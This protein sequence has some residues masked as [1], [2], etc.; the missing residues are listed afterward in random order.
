MKWSYE[1]TLFSSHFI[2]VKVHFTLSG[3]ISDFICIL[4]QC[5]RQ[6][7]AIKR[8]Y[9]VLQGQQQQQQKKIVNIEIICTVEGEIAFSF[10]GGCLAKEAPHFQWNFQCVVW[11]YKNIST[12]FF[13][14]HFPSI[15]YT[16]KLSSTCICLKDEFRSIRCLICLQY[17]EVLQPKVNRLSGIL[18]VT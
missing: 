14:H 10:P 16:L 15:V 3:F 9:S 12:V 7:L 5:W 17:S 1:A 8:I 4:N 2:Y 13:S 11:Q 18:S 6:S